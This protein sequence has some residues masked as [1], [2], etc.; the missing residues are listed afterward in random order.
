MSQEVLW[1]NVHKCRNIT[2]AKDTLHLRDKDSDL[3]Y[4]RIISLLKVMEEEV[5]RVH[6]EFLIVKELITG[7]S[8]RKLSGKDR[9]VFREI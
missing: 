1:G 6:L 9:C 3:R 4:G 8:R 7:A 5:N 2:D